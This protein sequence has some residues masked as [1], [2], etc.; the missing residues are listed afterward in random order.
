MAVARD[1]AFPSLLDARAQEQ[2]AEVLF[3]RA[4]ADVQLRRDFFVAAAL[5][6]KASELQ[7]SELR[8]HGG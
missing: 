2:C 7:A 5:H 1:Y 6:Q 8:G 3:D 4:W